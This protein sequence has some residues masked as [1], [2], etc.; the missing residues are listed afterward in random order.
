MWVIIAV[1]IVCLS[2]CTR[3]VARGWACI[4]SLTLRLCSMFSRRQGEQTRVAPLCNSTL[5]LSQFWPENAASDPGYPGKTT[6]KA[7][8]TSYSLH[9]V[10]LCHEPQ[11]GHCTGKWVS[12]DTGHVTNG[13]MCPVGAW[14]WFGSTATQMCVISMQIFPK[15]MQEFD[16]LYSCLYLEK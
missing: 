14:W 8:M 11:C 4:S 7:T 1:L 16:W 12:F 2:V 5:L 9:S 15:L 13:I 3:H 6:G 10:L